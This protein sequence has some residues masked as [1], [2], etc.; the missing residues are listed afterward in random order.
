MTKNNREIKSSN[1]VKEMKVRMN[2]KKTEAELKENKE[3]WFFMNRK[4]KF[5][6]KCREKHPTL[7]PAQVREWQMQ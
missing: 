2:Q 6:G 4:C 1:K 5:E 7:C 3:C